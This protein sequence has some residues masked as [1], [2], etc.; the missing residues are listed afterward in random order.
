[1]PFPEE[2]G[3]WAWLARKTDGHH[4]HYQQQVVGAELTRCQIDHWR[5]GDPKLLRL[6]PSFWKEDRGQK[7]I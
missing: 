6:I 5:P 1:M 3:M 4:R 7:M 2:L